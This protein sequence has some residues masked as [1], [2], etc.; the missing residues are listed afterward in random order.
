[1][2]QSLFGSIKSLHLRRLSVYTGAST[3]TENALVSETYP[4]SKHRAAA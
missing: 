2:G 3:K 4:D 1:M